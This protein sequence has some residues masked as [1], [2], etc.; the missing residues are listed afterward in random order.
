MCVSFGY[1]V[2]RPQ[3]KNSILISQVLIML[4]AL[5]GSIGLIEAEPRFF[6]AY[7]HVGFIERIQRAGSTLPNLDAR[8]SWPG[9][10][11]LAAM[12]TQ[13]SG[14]NS[15]KYFIRYSPVFFNAMYL[16]PLWIIA[17]SV[18]KSTR[19]HWLMMWT[20]LLGNWVGQDYLAPQALNYGLAI[21]FIAVLL[22]FFT[23]PPRDHPHARRPDALRRGRHLTP[24][25]QL[26]GYDRIELDKV[27]PAETQ[28]WQRVALL[29]FLLLTFFTICMSHQLTPLFVMGITVLLVLSR[30]CTLRSLP[31][32][33]V[34]I[35]LGWISLGADAFWKGHLQTVLSSFGSVGQNVN[36]GVAGRFT[37]SSE[38]QLVLYS[39][40]G[41]AAVMV[42][43][44]AIGVIRRWRMGVRQKGLII[45]TMAA[46][47]V[48]GLQSYGGEVVL[49]AYLFTLPLLAIFAALA[50]FPV[51]GRLRHP[52]ITAGAIAVLTS[53]IVPLFIVARFG[54]EEFERVDP[55]EAAAISYVYE[56]A[57]EGANLVAVSRNLPWRYRGIE[58]YR[59]FPVDDSILNDQKLL[60]NFLDTNS[61]ST[62]FL[63]T[64][65]Q[66][67]FG[68]QLYGLKPGWVAEVAK[69]LES[70]GR[71]R[72]VYSSPN[73]RA[74]VFEA[75]F[76][77]KVVDSQTVTP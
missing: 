71:F 74:Y 16:A 3:Q 63:L 15:A 60:I 66:E 49:R 68:I 42:G 19:A 65:S 59:Y 35:Y 7:L 32:I 77:A 5:H 25:T 48:V 36:S 72:I 54:N 37:G 22:R 13:V 17:R 6:S 67:R 51:P 56:H 31:L 40:M 53:L 28:G 76:E 33:Q 8:Y 20:F 69:T 9:S 10:F 38:R 73:A 2:T 29:A 18:T 75:N 62:Y 43:F 39:R 61:A 12:L 27:E 21:T 14:L 64:T 52:G 70:T 58:L 4:F 1:A 41:F 46:I 26:F 24:R 57:P 30:R 34:V 47:P 44:A 50:I 23:V 11:S 55:Q 45:A